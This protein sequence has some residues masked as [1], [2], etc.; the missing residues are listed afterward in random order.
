MDPVKIP[1]YIDAN[2]VVLLRWTADELAIFG[3][4]FV[5][6]IIISHPTV[7]MA[8]GMASVSGF[9]RYRNSKSDGFLMHIMYWWGLVPLRNRSIV[10]PFHRRI[11]PS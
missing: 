9:G 8:L 7:G 4:M 11:L 10:N 2:Q 3:T 6:G 1:R 5:I